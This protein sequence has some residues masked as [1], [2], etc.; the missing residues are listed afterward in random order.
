MLNAGSHEED[1]LR[2]EDIN[3][4][5]EVGKRIL[6]FLDKEVYN[7]NTM[8][9]SEF[10]H[11]IPIFQYSGYEEIGPE[12]YNKIC[13]DWLRRIC[14][15]HP[16]RI[17]NDKNIEEVLFVMPPMWNTTNAVS[18]TPAGNLA[19]SG[20]TNANKMLDEF[21]IHKQKWCSVFAQ[22]IV[23]AQ[24]MDELAANK[25]ESDRI[26][27][28]LRSRGIIGGKPGEIVVISNTTEP[29]PSHTPSAPVNNDNNNPVNLETA[30]DDFDIM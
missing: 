13:Q 24:R 25:Q 8:R 1:Y 5:E 4:D 29:S 16:V 28:E 10:R 27:A 19:V 30:N 11:Y 9:L 3:N 6:A 17:V 22:T 15:R 26:E 18:I 2:V 7:R 14:P 20:F 21:H 12:R 23:D